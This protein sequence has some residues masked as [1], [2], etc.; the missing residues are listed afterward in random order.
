MHFYVEG[1]R[2]RG[3]VGLHLVKNPRAMGDYEY[4]YFYVDI[5]GQER[6][7]LENA[8]A[9]PASQSGGDKKFKF[10]GVTWA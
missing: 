9:K 6:I 5:P 1:P 2:N 7:Y 4:K 10:L 3:T 8:D